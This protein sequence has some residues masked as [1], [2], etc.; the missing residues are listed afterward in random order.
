MPPL[1]RA[2]S[3][4]IGVNQPRRNS[5]GEPLEHSEAIAWRMAGI[6][7]RAGYDSLLVLRGE[8]ATRQAVHDALAGAARAMGRGDSLLVT[9]SGH[10]TQVRDHAYGFGAYP[11]ERDGWDEAWC[12]SDGL[13]VDDKLAGYW[14]LFESGVRIVVVS[15]SCFGGGMGRIGEESYL[16]G[17][18]A[19]GSQTPLVYGGLEGEAWDPGGGAEWCVEPPRNA[20]GIQASL[21]LLAACGEDQHA[22][23][24]VFS[25][26]LFA[27]WA[28][29][30][31]AGSY[32]ELYRQLYDR[33]VAEGC[34]QQ[35]RIEMAGA[36][37]LA[38][39]LEPAFHLKRRALHG[40]P[41]YR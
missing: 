1:P 23:E 8:E 5:P 10:G 20:H 21:L 33:V 30:D 14:R 19:G 41:A 13:M 31:F 7:E 26:H 24:G 16:Y 38:F 12:L 34:G 11:E 28:D 29:G 18:A 9:F 4:H 37:D 22:Q 3:I 39:P 27:V 36:T 6:A 32:C 17:E 35:P 40:R 2:V 15:D 25:R